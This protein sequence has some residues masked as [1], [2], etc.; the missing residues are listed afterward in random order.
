M[1]TTPQPVPQGAPPTGGAPAGASGGG[2]QVMQLIAVITKASQAL[3]QV[4]PAATPD[5]EVI[6]SALQKVMAKVNETTKPAQPQAPP[7]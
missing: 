6:T 5:T 4:F 7:I 1:A 2:P 3:A